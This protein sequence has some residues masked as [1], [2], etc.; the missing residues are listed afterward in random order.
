MIRIS[1]PIFALAA[2]LAAGRGF[3][4]E[5]TPPGPGPAPDFPQVFDLLRAHLEGFS[6]AELNR[7]AVDGLVTALSPKVAL[8]S[9]EADANAGGE[10]G[11]GEKLLVSKSGLFDGEIGYVRISRVEEGLAQAVRDACAKA[12]GTNALKGVVLDLRYA[13]GDN[14]AA[15][16][17]TVDLFLKKE[18]PLLD[19]GKGVVRS[20]EKEDAIGAPVAVLVNHETAAAAEALTAVL[21]ATGSGLILG[22]KTAGQAFVAEEYPLKNGQRLRIAKA[23]IQLGD[24]TALSSQG[25]KPDIQVEVNPQEERAYYLDAFKEPAS[26][27]LMSRGTLSLTNQVSGTN[28]T[29][30]PRFSEAELIRERRDGLLPELDLAGGAATEKPL[31]RDPVLGRALD[32]LKGLA[33]VGQSRS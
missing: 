2:L 10:K 3:T 22:G 28:R 1:S 11:P 9:T 4:A 32:V 8:V 25:V 16:A 29:R 18:R 14:Y 21:R 6:E 7:A 23:P 17:D 31:V 19:W 33:V 20:K 15:A 24:G 12:A 26:G 5:P 13:G 27:N 30:R